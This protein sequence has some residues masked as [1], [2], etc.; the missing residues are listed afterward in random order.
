MAAEEGGSAGAAP[1]R[2]RPGSWGQ[3]KCTAW[4]RGRLNAVLI[5]LWPHDGPGGR[6]WGEWVAVRALLP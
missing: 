6:G 1:V 4:G 2:P 3:G 5:P